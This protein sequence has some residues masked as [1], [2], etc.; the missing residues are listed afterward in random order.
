MNPLF[1]TK[2]YLPP[3]ET[4][5][6]QLRK[7]W[8]CGQVANNG[9]CVRELEAKLAERFGVKHAF[10][11][12]NGTLA[13]QIAVHALELHGEI[14]TTPF[15][16]VATT[17]SLIWEGCQPVFVDID[18]DTFTLAPAE[19]EAAITD[20][21]T[22]IFATHV[23]GRCCDI[24]AIGEIAR[25]HNLKVV[26]DGAH[27]FDVDY[28]GASVF[29]YGDI[30][31][32]SFHA[33]KLFHTVEGGALF[34]G[35]DGIAH[36]IAYMRNFGHKGQEEFWGVGINGKMSELHA[37]MGLCTL[38]AVPKLIAQRRAASAAYDR[39]LAH[40]PGALRPVL[41]PETGPNFSYYPVLFASEEL[42]LQVRDALQSHGIQP[43]R[44]FYPSLHTLDFLPRQP[45]PVAEDVSRR[46]LCLP[47]SAD[48]A[49]DD[50][51][52]VARIVEQAVSLAV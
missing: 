22:A 40:C 29:Q 52:T 18:P 2:V 41:T 17:S 39:E 28:E 14:I 9:P 26:Y 46:V 7:I 5:V 42:L 31:M 34:T 12:A 51:R 50:A 35:D 47:L 45:M 19:I 48:L 25:R 20:R 16:Y 33:T 13:L 4:Y 38:P 32:T 36:K 37:A 44:Y 21:T 23:Y 6:A 43:R 10:L 24:R 11:I 49:P 1:V 15:S 3:L 30:A 27:A 8:E